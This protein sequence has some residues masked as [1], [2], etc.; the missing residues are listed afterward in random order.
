VSVPPIP[1]PDADSDFEE[2]LRIA[3]EIGSAPNQAWAHYSFGMLHMVHGHFGRA[4]EEMQ[5]GLHIASEIGHREYM[6]GARFALGILN[7]GLFAPDQA[8]GQLEGAL[9]LARE[10][11]SPIWTHVVSGGLS[12]AYL[13]LDDQKSAKACLEAA[14]SQQ[15][16]MDSLGKRYCWVRRAEL[17]IAQDDPA[18][19]LDITERLITSAPGMSPG[20]VI[21]F[22]WQLKGEA[23][24]AMGHTEEACS[25]LQAAKENTRRT[26]ERFL[27]GR[28]HASLGQLHHIMN[29][30]TQAEI[31]FSAAR[32]LIQEFSATI[33]DETL[34]ENFTQGVNGL[35]AKRPP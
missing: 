8:L 16:P 33:P 11:R 10:L 28:I 27:L 17:A 13:L 20:Q 6:V 35:L 22:L 34:K 2:A 23:L 26:E 5:R 19:A 24:A 9:T 1:P 4:I 3:V 32:K 31:E 18:L 30:H 15:T 21:T 12:E 29:R 7:V 14:I 25:L